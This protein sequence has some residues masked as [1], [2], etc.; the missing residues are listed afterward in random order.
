MK[1]ADKR[2]RVRKAVAAE[3]AEVARLAGAIWELAELPLQ[4]TRSANLLAE[5]LAARGFKV[6]WPM[7]VLPTAFKA[8][9]GAGRPTIGFLGEYDALPDCGLEPGSNGHGCGHNLLGV[10]AAAGAAAAA[11]LLADAKQ[12]GRVVYWGC[13]AEEAIGGKVYMARDGAFR[14]LDACLCWHPGDKSCVRAAGGA[15]I[16]SVL[17]DFTG[18]TAHAGGAPERG[19]SALD[20]VV[21]MDVAVN[22]LREHVPENVRIHCVFPEAGTAPNVVPDRARAWYYVRGAD[23]AQVDDLVRRVKLCA[24]GAAMATET[25]FRS[26]IISSFHSR[27]PNDVMAD[28]VRQNLILMGGTPRATE[29]DRRRARRVRKDL[30]FHKGVNLE[31]GTRQGRASSDEDTVS[32]L[33]PLGSFAIGCVGLGTRGH[34]WEETAQVNLPFAHR[35]AVRCAEV[36]AATAWDLFADAKRLRA[37]RAE[38][39]R[40]TQGVTYDPLLSKSLRPSTKDIYE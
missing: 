38:F 26:K 1:P 28:T 11:R 3:R 27:L 24:R 7:A 17:F 30:E 32:Q 39:R 33:T 18:Q 36:F 6:T 29:A 34:H 31:A 19:R 2:R 12:R 10:G 40:R 8:V 20:A 15:A 13:P 14:A 25:S 21:L 4:E 16:D 35:G 5:Y 22:Y 23:R 37:A 9:W